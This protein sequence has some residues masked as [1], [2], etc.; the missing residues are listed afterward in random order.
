MRGG[1][2]EPTSRDQRTRKERGKGKGDSRKSH[3][4]EEIIGVQTKAA[5]K[6]RAAP[7]ATKQNEEPSTCAWTGDHSCHAQR[8][9]DDGGWDARSWTGARCF[10][11]V[12]STGLRRHRFVGD[13]PQRRFSSARLATWCTAAV[14]AVARMVGRKDKVE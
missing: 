6:S 1:T 3:R 4:E 7:P 8:P 14:S 9:D 11:C 10:E 5:R 13:P 12:R 2:A